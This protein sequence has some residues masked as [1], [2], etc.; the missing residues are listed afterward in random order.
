MLLP[1][2]EVHSFGYFASDE[3]TSNLQTD[4]QGSFPQRTGTILF[5]GTFGEHFCAGGIP[6]SNRDDSQKGLFLNPTVTY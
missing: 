4:Y 5:Q 1:A 3:K 6:G 2:E